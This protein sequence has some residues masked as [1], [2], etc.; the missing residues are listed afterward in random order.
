MSATGDPT[1]D[2]L[3]PDAQQLLAGAWG[4]FYAAGL[5]QDGLAQ[6][7]GQRPDIR[8]ATL[9]N[10]AYAYELS[11]KA[12]LAAHG[13]DERYLSQTV[14]HNLPRALSEAV[15]FG[16]P[17]DPAVEGDVGLLAVPFANHT[18]RYGGWGDLELPPRPFAVLERHLLAVSTLLLIPAE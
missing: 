2:A 10:V 17:A 3:P 16:L 11:L 9:V 1:I 15:A 8:P 5:A 7:Q 4:F 6:W 12:V 14:R 18:L 13:R